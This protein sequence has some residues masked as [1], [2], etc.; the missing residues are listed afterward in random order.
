MVTGREEKSYKCDENG[1]DTVFGHARSTSTSTDVVRLRRTASD[2]N[3]K[4]KHNPQTGSTNNV[5]TETDID[6]ISVA[7]PMFLRTSF[8]MV[9]MP[10]SPDASFIQILQADKRISEVVVTLRRK[11][12]QRDLSGYSSVLG[13]VRS[14]STGVNIVGLRRTA[15]S[16]KPEVETVSQTGSTNNLEQQKQIST[17]SQWI[18]LCFWEQIFFTGVQCESKKSPLR[19]SEIFSPNGWEFLLNFYTHLLCVPFYT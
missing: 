7:M 12:Y 16:C 11:R 8:S 6:T 10:T 14:I 1:S 9:Y 4:W 17:L 3:R 13:H 5:A 15:F 2:T 19:F 18:Y